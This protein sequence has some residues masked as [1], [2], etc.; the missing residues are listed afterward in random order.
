MLD[1]NSLTQRGNDRYNVDKPGAEVDTMCVPVDVLR[2]ALE[3]I[4]NLP[5]ALAN[6][7]VVQDQDSGAHRCED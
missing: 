2:S 6:D 7:P 4:W 1:R 3:E 5:C